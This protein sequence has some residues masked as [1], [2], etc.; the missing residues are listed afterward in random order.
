MERA[1]F[2]VRKWWE[3]EDRP[4]LFELH[5]HAVAVGTLAVCLAGLVVGTADETFDLH[6]AKGMADVRVEPHDNWLERHIQEV[7]HDI[8]VQAEQAEQG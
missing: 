7:V 2:R 5:R 1:Y 4:T 8:G 3:N 6:L